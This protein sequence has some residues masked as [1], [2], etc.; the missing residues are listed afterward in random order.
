MSIVTLKSE[1]LM[2]L[3]LKMCFSCFDSYYPAFVD[4]ECRRLRKTIGRTKTQHIFRIDLTALS[5][6]GYPSNDHR[7]AH[8]A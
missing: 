5:F 3:S 6:L 8:V 2:A 7:I 4:P 1:L